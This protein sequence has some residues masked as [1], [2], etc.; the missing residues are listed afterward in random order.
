[1]KALIAPLVLGIAALTASAS[2]AAVDLPIAAPA[3]VLQA[4][5]SSAPPASPPLQCACVFDGRV[6]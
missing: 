5:S 4:G 2:F 6:A 3:A 1:M